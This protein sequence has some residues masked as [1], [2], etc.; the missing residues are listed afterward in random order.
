M[1]VTHSRTLLTLRRAGRPSG[2]RRRLHNRRAQRMCGQARARRC[3][4]WAWPCRATVAV[5]SQL[6][7]RR[8]AS[9]RG[10][11]NVQMHA[12]RGNLGPRGLARR[13]S[14]RAALPWVYYGGLCVLVALC[15]SKT[16]TVLIPGTVG[17]HVADDSEG[18]VLALLLPA[19][20][21]YIRPRVAGRRSEWVV[22]AAAAAVMFGIFLL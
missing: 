14:Y 18:Y 19:W 6:S 22:T 10:W 12:M 1:V 16:L 3:R 7:D 17:R 5:C 2:G 9:L 13:R 15:A 11:H 20:I 21:E 8:S 4:P